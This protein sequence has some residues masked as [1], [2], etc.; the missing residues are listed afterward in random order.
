MVQQLRQDEPQYSC[1][2]PIESIT[3]NQDEEIV[4]FGV[5][6]WD[7]KNK[8]KQLLVDRYGCNDDEI[9][10]LLQLAQIEQLSNWCSP[11]NSQG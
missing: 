1:T 8:A 11:G 4:A 5:S 9:S 10:Q 3:G 7:T 2:V 6:V